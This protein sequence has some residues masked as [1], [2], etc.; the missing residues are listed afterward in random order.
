MSHLYS[1]KGQIGGDN[2]NHINSRDYRDQSPFLSSLFLLSLS[3]NNYQT[4]PSPHGREGEGQE[5]AQEAKA[6]AP[7]HRPDSNIKVQ[8][9]SLVPG[10][11]GLRLQAEL[12]GEGPAVRRPAHRQVLHDPPGEAAGAAPGPLLSAN[13]HREAKRAPS[14]PFHRRLPPHQLHH[15]GPPSLAHPNPRPRHQEVEGARVRVRVRVPPGLRRRPVL[16]PRDPARGGEPPAHKARARGL[17]AGPVQV[18]EG[19]HHV[20]RLRGPPSR[21]GGLLTRRRPPDDSPV[22][23]GAERLPGP[24]GHAGYA[25]SEEHQLLLPPQYF[26]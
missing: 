16:A 1:K 20:L 13:R 9:S 19:V 3:T 6:Q 7:K 17:R 23:G 5:E 4:R 10:I 11:I 24:H 21:H 15:P 12:R 26:S 8:E 18:P 14:V 2:T 25:Q 22:G